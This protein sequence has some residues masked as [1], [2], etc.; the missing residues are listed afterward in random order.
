MKLENGDI[1]ITYLPFKDNTKF[2][3]LNGKWHNPEQ[4][5]EYTE[6]DCEMISRLLSDKSTTWQK[7]KNIFD[8]NV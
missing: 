7:I 4:K 2:L 3:W 6:T 1:I 5:F 8:Y